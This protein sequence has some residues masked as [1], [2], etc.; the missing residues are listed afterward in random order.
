MNG[1]IAGNGTQ[2]AAVI[3]GN[4]TQTCSNQLKLKKAANTA[5]KLDK[6][7]NSGINKYQETEAGEEDNSN[8]QMDK[9]TET[10]R[11]S[12]SEESNQS[13]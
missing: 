6:D 8:I 13:M 2:I 7:R 5:M 1:A 4:G 3:A 10:Y 9:H 11:S 12:P